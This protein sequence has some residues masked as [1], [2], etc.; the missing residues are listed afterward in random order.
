MAFLTDLALLR[1]G[2][3]IEVQMEERDKAGKPVHRLADLLGLA[4][5]MPPDQRFGKLAGR[6]RQG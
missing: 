3:S 2:R 5:S 1:F 6:A 4:A